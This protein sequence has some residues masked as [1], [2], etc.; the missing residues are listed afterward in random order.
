MF[1][2]QSASHLPLRPFRCLLAYLLV[3]ALVAPF[4]VRGAAGRGAPA[5]AESMSVAAAARPAGGSATWREGELLV[6]FREEVTER[7][8]NEVARAQGAR[9]GAKLRGASRV[10]K[11][12]L[13]PGQD[14][15]AVAAE[16]RLRPEVELAEPNF[17]IARSQVIP[18]DARF[19]EQWA[20]RNTGQAGGEVGADTRAAEA[21]RETTGSAS[22]VV[23]VVDTLDNAHA[24]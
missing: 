18:D 20:L 4:G 14:A 17:L 10:Q 6:R 9:R 19:S 1:E 2:S 24:V 7:D 15:A 23:A 21:W 8:R 22:T 11:M 3:C 5:K 13:Q 16:L 12:A